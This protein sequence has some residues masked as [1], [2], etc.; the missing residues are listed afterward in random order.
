MISDEDIIAKAVWSL[1]I[2]PRDV[3][4]IYH[5]FVSTIVAELKSGRSVTIPDIGTLSPGNN[6]VDF[7]P[8]PSAQQRS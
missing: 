3:V 4:E 6:G 7:A 5:R 8:A 2:P 1:H